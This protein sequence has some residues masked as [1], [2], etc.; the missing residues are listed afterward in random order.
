[1]KSVNDFSYDA[2]AIFSRYGG[3][4]SVGKLLNDAGIK[5]NVRTLQ[6]QKER[7]VI[8]THMLAALQLASYRAGI[9]LDYSEYILQ[10]ET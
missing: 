7:G 6:K 1:M 2:G 8:P 9:P 3:V 10:R 5:V 4:A